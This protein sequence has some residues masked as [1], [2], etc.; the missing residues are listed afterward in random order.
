MARQESQEV[1]PPVAVETWS[2]FCIFITSTA[3]PIAPLHYM[4]KARNLIVRSKFC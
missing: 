2:R 4:K 3:K 1:P